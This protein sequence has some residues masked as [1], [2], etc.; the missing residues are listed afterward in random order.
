MNTSA[1]QF[2]EYIL[3]NILDAQ[4]P[5]EITQTEDAMGTL[6]EVKVDS[7][8]MGKVIGKNGQTIQALRTLVRMIGSK[9]GERVTLKVLEPE[10]A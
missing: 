4:N 8:S 6:L 2:L 10:N 9:T 1:K 5:F 7:V 3:Q